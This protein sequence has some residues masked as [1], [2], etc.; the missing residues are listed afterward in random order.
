MLIAY[1]SKTGNVGRFVKKLDMRNIKIEEDTILN[2]PF[3]LITYTTGFGKAPKKTLDFLEK[4]SKY[5]VGVAASGNRNWGDNFCKSAITIANIYNIPVIHR[6]ELQG[7]KRDVQKFKD[8]VANIES[9][10][11]KQ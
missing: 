9:H 3:V 7:T 4:N 2:E 6:F 8:E 10:R 5:I 11:I 1:D